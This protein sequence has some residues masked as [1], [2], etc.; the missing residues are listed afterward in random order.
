MAE[1]PRSKIKEPIL[2]ESKSLMI[3]GL[4]HHYTGGTV[5]E[6]PQLWNRFVQHL[7]K[8]AIRWIGQHTASVSICASPGSTILLE[9]KFRISQLSHR[10]SPN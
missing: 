8:I 6:I 9:W 5:S 10:D 7:G 2:R 3:A 1:P 4:Q